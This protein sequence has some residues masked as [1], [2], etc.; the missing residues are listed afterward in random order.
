LYVCNPTLNKFYSRLKP[1]KPK[2]FV[3]LVG[4]PAKLLN[5]D[6]YVVGKNEEVYDA[7]LKIKIAA[8]IAF[9]AQDTIDTINFV[10]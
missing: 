5:P 9:A 3:G 4:C 7:E 2:P 6:V 8:D 10:S 1:R